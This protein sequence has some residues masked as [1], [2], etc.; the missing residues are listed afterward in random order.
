[1][2]RIVLFACAIVVLARVP[3]GA[4]RPTGVAV[5]GTVVD[6]TGAILQAA[7]VEVRNASGATVQSVTTDQMGVFALAPLP[8]GRYDLLVTFEGFQPTTVRVN[9]GTRA[10]APIRVALPLAKIDQQLTVGNS[11]ADVTTDAASNLDSSTIDQAMLDKLPVFNQDILATMSRFLDS[12][13]IGT[14]VTLIVNGIEVNS[15]MVPASAIQQIKINSDPYSAEFFRPGRGRIEVIT[16][17]GSQQYEGVASV[18]FRDA[19]L[20]ARNAFSTSRPSEQR[21]IFEGFFGGPIGHSDKTSFTLSFKSDAE[22]AEAIV[23]AQ[24]LSGAIRQNVPTPSRS[25]LAA[26]TVTHQRGKNTTMALTASYQDDKTHNQGVG[27]VAL[28]STGVD[29]NSIEQDVT[30]NQQTVVTPKLLNQFRIL[31]GQE[32][33]TWTSANGDP[34]LIVLD[35]FTGGGAQADRFRTEH[36]ATLTDTVTWSSVRHVV[37]MGLNVPDWSRRRFD[38][39]ANRGGTSIFRASGISRPVGRIPSSSRRETA[40]S[41]FS[42]SRSA[43]FFR[44]TSASGPICRSRWACATTG[45]TSRTT[46]TT[47]RRD[48]RLRTRQS[49]TARPSSGAAPACSTT[50][51]VPARSRTSFATTASICSATCSRI[52]AIRIP[53]FPG[54]RSAPIRLAWS[55]SYPTS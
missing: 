13:A 11:A 14:G 16:K 20:D 50:A 21:R 24:D 31:V 4:Q 36:H 1:M 42:T 40:T 43:D 44:T 41:S 27:G 26:A 3:A 29:W 52:P 7:R 45:R 12:S 38:D 47:W 10:P 32:Y 39:N 23:V 9:V 15:L 37:T 19:S 49:A 33:E 30:Y 8:S 46:A 5:S 25:I 35:A 55:D 34:A 28:P 17:P 18:T 48:C 51:R 54:S 53:S 2:K 6:Q 22:D